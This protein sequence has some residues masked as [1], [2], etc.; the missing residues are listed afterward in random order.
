MS[1]ESEQIIENLI[2]FPFLC[3]LI[4][5]P[6][7]IHHRDVK[8]DHLL[9][10]NIHNLSYDDQTGNFF[11]YVLAKIYKNR[12]DQLVNSLD[13]LDYSDHYHDNNNN[14][15]GYTDHL[16]RWLKINDYPF[17]LSLSFDCSRRITMIACSA[18]EIIQICH[19]GFVGGVN[20]ISDTDLINVITYADLLQMLLFFDRQIKVPQV[21]RGV[22]PL[23]LT[24]IDGQNFDSMLQEISVTRDQWFHSL[25]LEQ[26]NLRAIKLT[27]WLLFRKMLESKFKMIL[28]F[29]N[30]P[31]SDNNFSRYACHNREWRREVYRS[32]YFNF[33]KIYYMIR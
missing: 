3:H 2:K 6:D 11:D 21:S 13:S 18:M 33:T 23:D 20:P 31:E 10:N 15:N 8:F 17:S 32:F 26:M 25:K 27:N 30:D 22:I 7:K 12:K 14:N 1:K 16:Q 5:L 28:D 29:I 9:G 24:L 4:A 19:H